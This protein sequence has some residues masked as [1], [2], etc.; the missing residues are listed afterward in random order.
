MQGTRGGLRVVQGSGQAAIVESPDPERFQA[1]CVDA[2]VASWVARGFSEVTIDSATSRLERVLTAVGKPAWEVTRD[3]I[4]RVVGTWAAAGIAASTRRGYVQA[5]KGFHEFLVARKAAAARGGVRCSLES[6]LD[7]F[8]AA[9]HVGNES[10][11]TKAPPTAQRLEEF[12]EYL[13]ERIATARKF[14]SAGRDYALFRTLYHAGV[15]AE[16]AAALELGDLHFGRV[17]SASSTCASA[18][19]PRRRALGHGGCRC[20]TGWI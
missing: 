2:Y 9:R 14:A 3:D 19:A 7:E 1:D 13:R 17:R 6:P 4:D 8:N 5:F 12:F 16:E 15:R 18:R 11:S 20:S 10:A